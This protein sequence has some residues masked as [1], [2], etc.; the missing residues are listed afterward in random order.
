L[1]HQRRFHRF[2]VQQPEQSLDRTVGADL[3]VPLF[4]PVHRHRRSKLLPQRRRQLQHFV[5][6]PRQL[7][8]DPLE[9][10]PGAVGLPAETGYQLFDFRW[11]QFDQETG[12]V[13]L[14]FFTS[15]TL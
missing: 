3:E 4:E 7:L 6:R 1:W 15:E 11:H 14:P 5:P 8:V 10:L 12:H 13:A 2:A 9:H